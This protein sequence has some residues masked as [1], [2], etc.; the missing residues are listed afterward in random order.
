MFRKYRPIDLK[1]GSEIDV[2]VLFCFF[3]FFACVNGLL[4]GKNVN[5]VLR[6]VHV[7]VNCV[8]FLVQK[9]FMNSVH[10]PFTIDELSSELSSYELSSSQPWTERGNI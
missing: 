8:Q 1:R 5:S 7:H 9:N 6:S 4:N 10:G 3:F 2:F